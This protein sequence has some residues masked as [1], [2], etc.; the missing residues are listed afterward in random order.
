[1]LWLG[2]ASAVVLINIFLGCAFIYGFVKMRSWVFLVIGLWNFIA[3]SLMLWGTCRELAAYV[4]SNQ[5]FSDRC[6]RCC[7]LLYKI[8]VESMWFH[9]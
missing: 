4:P 2:A 9:R 1:M 8:V 3:A 5:S 6:E 7:V